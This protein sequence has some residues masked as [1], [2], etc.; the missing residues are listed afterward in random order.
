MPPA[1]LAVIASVVCAQ[2]AIDLK[3]FCDGDCKRP[4]KQ[5][6]EGDVRNYKSAASE[7]SRNTPD[8]VNPWPYKMVD[9][10]PQN[11]AFQCNQS[12]W[13][14]PCFQYTTSQR[15]SWLDDMS[16]VKA[17]PTNSWFTDLFSHSPILVY[18]Q[19]FA[20]P[21]YQLPYS[22]I[23][24]QDG[25]SI[26]LPQYQVATN[27]GL[28]GIAGDIPV[29]RDSAIAPEIT[30]VD[31]DRILIVSATVPFPYQ[32]RRIKSFDHSTLG[33]SLTYTT[34]A[35]NSMLYH[36]VKGHPYITIESDSG[37]TPTFSFPT[38]V[39]QS[40]N[41]KECNTGC[42]TFPQSR[43]PSL[44]YKYKIQI[45]GNNEKWY[46]YIIYSSV[47]LNGSVS[48]KGQEWITNGCESNGC[49][50][51]VAVT[52]LARNE[53]ING[54]SKFSARWTSLSGGL[55]QVSEDAMD[56]HA[57]TYPVS[58]N[59]ET[60]VS[61][62]YKDGRVIQQLSWNTKCVVPSCS[63]ADL[64]MLQLPHHKGYAT[65]QTQSQP[66]VQYP[67]AT[68]VATGYVGSRWNL[69][70]PIADLLGKS[71]G[72]SSSIINF[73]N[74]LSD[75]STSSLDPFAPF[76]SSKPPSSDKINIV[77]ESL[78]ADM[79]YWTDVYNDHIVRSPAFL[80]LTAD[81]YSFGKFLGAISRLIL[82]AD[83]VGDL[84]TARVGRDFL[85]CRLNQ[86]F[87][88]NQI[89]SPYFPF[90]G[91]Q[92]PV[93]GSLQG[94]VPVY[95]STWGGL[96]TTNGLKSP[97][98]TWIR[99]GTQP[100]F[101][102]GGYNDHLFHYGYYLYSVSVVLM[103]SKVSGGPLPGQGLSYDSDICLNNKAT[104]SDW[105]TKLS[106][107][108]FAMARDI[109]NPSQESDPYFTQFRYHSDWYGGMSWARG[110]Y[111]SGQTSSNIESTSEGTQAWYSLFLL[112]YAMDQANVIPTVAS[113][114]QSAG[115][116]LLISDLAA[117]TTYFHIL[118]HGSGGKYP[119]RD[120]I[121]PEPFRGLGI[122]GNF[123]SNTLN[124]QVFFSYGK[125][126]WSGS[127]SSDDCPHDLSLEQIHW[128]N[129]LFVL[130]IQLLPYTPMTET[131][132]ESMWT[133]QVLITD[134]LNYTNNKGM[135]SK[136][137]DPT[138]IWS[139]LPSAYTKCNGTTQNLGNRCAQGWLGYA[140]QSWS[141]LGDTQRDTA[142]SQALSMDGVADGS[143]IS[144]LLWWISTR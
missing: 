9:G 117:I 19:V 68:G 48:V 109:A 128:F 75:T 132:L 17:I 96:P 141:A 118:P 27:G 107:R 25:V 13:P 76:F 131:L 88:P 104:D 135:V 91:E 21:I 130:Q 89:S 31:V 119:H 115:S 62:S 86:W 113:A 35:N 44:L 26:T 84:Q 140:Y 143:T 60:P 18:P 43:L 106:P 29:D 142:W 139:D 7:I 114:L 79:A 63:S 55:L 12:Q 93:K 78:K 99:N 54:T 85:R 87:D 3:P 127:S 57:N 8:G 122:T 50:L 16:D 72:I 95:D 47:L 92:F 144:N 134:R 111:P 2:V 32:N 23:A 52:E 112:G 80:F 98:P 46:V 102:S 137:Y 121:V 36:L 20:W 77:K 4:D 24:A 138:A 38:A 90:V 40:I 61:H 83:E 71:T 67:V 37:I 69:S 41:G 73:F 70:F 103:G 58:I 81:C 108:V 100:D 116:L 64:L 22:L 97:G 14:N 129:R 28:P 105:F 66:R 53:A 65:D 136:G 110:L 34:A 56:K 45:N 126:Q 10:W 6:P 101:G 30:G 125:C 5:F 11:P 51:R 120:N 94:G 33:A 1:A 59:K 124:Y 49:T 39:L 74:K 15:S 42:K 133:Q 123:W 82:I